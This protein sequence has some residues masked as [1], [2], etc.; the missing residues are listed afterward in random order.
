[1]DRLENRDNRSFYHSTQGGHSRESTVTPHYVDGMNSGQPSTPS[2]DHGKRRGSHYMDN[3]GSY[4]HSTYGENHGERDTDQ[5]LNGI[6]SNLHPTESKQHGNRS[7]QKHSNHMSIGLRSPN[8][9]HDGKQ[10]KHHQ[11]TEKSESTQKPRRKKARGKAELREHLFQQALQPFSIDTGAPYPCSQKHID[12]HRRNVFPIPNRGPF[13]TCR[14][15]TKEV[16]WQNDIK[17]PIPPL[18]KAAINRLLLAATR[19]E[20]GFIP[21][22]DVA[23]KAFSDLD[24]VFFGGQLHNH[25]TVQWRPDITIPNRSWGLCHR[26][27]RGEEGQCRIELNASMIFR[28]GWTTRTKNPFESMIGTLLHEMCHAYVNVRSPHHVEPGDGHGELFGTRITVVHNRALGILGLW[29]IERGEKHR[30]HH[31]FMPG[32]LEDQSDRQPGKGSVSGGKNRDS[33]KQE[34]KGKSSRSGKRKAGQRVDNDTKAGVKSEAGASSAK[35]KRGP[36]DSD[37]QGP[38]CLM[39]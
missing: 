6:S 18:E 25:V 5:H 28:E 33:V 1:M 24:L 26:A 39:M 13:T 35:P 3:V 17:R 10:S 30:Q 14:E 20:E 32:C 4:Y 36:K 15:A 8:R 34:S 22:P 23:I 37:W 19:A 21:G 31:F 2:K 27:L 29:A 16:M 9:T 12:F 11:T 7:P 38:A